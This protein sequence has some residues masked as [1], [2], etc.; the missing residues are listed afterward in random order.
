MASYTVIDADGHV[1]ES[2]SGLREFLEPRWQRA[3]QFV[4]Q[5]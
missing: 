4:S 2:M 3:P 1:R 5:R